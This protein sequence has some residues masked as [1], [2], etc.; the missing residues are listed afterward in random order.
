MEAEQSSLSC[1][2]LPLSPKGEEEGD[3][4]VSGR[5]PG[6]FLK[7]HGVA[8]FSNPRAACLTGHFSL[9]RNSP[10]YR[11][12]V[13]QVVGG[14]LI[15]HFL[16]GQAGSCYSEP[17]RTVHIP[18]HKGILPYQRLLEIRVLFCR[19]RGR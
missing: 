12:M 15:K 19:W 14:M 11:Q 13:L 18:L 16:A 1:K 6:K 10:G 2:S 4:S 8:A 3:D 5:Q 7:G 9:L 17:Q